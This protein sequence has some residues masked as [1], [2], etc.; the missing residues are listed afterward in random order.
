MPFDEVLGI[1]RPA[2]L[3]FD[4]SLVTIGE[5]N[6]LFHQVAD[7]RASHFGQDVALIDPDPEFSAGLN[8]LDFLN[9]EADTFTEDVAEIVKVLLPPLKA[10]SSE[11]VTTCGDC[12]RKAL[13][14]VITKLIS[15]RG[16]SRPSLPDVHAFFTPPEELASKLREMD[17]IASDFPVDYIAHVRATIMVA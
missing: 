7:Y 5:F 1:A 8:P 11:I 4:G 15:T 16:S 17:V 14:A 12:A 13:H 9:P 6:W 3:A 2:A 10:K